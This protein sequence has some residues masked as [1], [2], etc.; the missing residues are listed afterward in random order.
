[1]SGKWGLVR[2]GLRTILVFTSCAIDSMEI[3]SRGRGFGMHYA[4]SLRWPDIPHCA[5]NFSVRTI[6]RPGNQ[7]N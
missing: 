1:M 5:Q 7:E 3:A 4:S 2:S 6:A